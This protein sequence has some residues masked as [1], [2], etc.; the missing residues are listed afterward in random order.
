MIQI[1]KKEFEDN[2]KKLGFEQHTNF[3]NKENMKYN[4]WRRKFDHLGPLKKAL[5]CENT[6]IKGRSRF[7]RLKNGSMKALK[8][9]V[10]IAAGIAGTAAGI[11][12]MGSATRSLM[13][14][15]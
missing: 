7:R 10:P 14:K 1:K 3:K 15:S 2:A 8:A 5:G 13:S 12:G 11:P 4:L 6:K 9:S